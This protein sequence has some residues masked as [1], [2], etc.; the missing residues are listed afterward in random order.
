MIAFVDCYGPYKTARANNRTHLV[1]VIGVS[2]LA[3]MLR[4]CPLIWDLLSS[5]RL[6]QDAR[7]RVLPSMMVIGPRGVDNGQREVGAE[8][9][10]IALQQRNKRHEAADDENND[11]DVDDEQAQASSLQPRH[12]QGV[13]EPWRPSGDSQRPRYLMLL[14]FHIEFFA[15]GSEAQPT[16]VW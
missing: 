12:A 8:K 16:A 6:V 11:D 1:I 7:Y 10:L 2:L 13:L 9:L 15:A 3:S 4:K 5:S 14:V